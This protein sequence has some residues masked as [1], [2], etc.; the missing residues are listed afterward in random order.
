[1]AVR[2]KRKAEAR[3]H[4]EENKETG[5]WH[6]NPNDIRAWLDTL[7]D[8]EVANCPGEHGTEPGFP[9]E[10]AFNVTSRNEV[11]SVEHLAIVVHDPDYITEVVPK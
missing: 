5:K 6:G 8:A 3:K 7:E 4:H 2:E 1:M 10:Q 9:S 11:T